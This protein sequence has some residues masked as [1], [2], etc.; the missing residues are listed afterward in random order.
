MGNAS[1]SFAVFTKPWK[2]KTLPELG[3]FVKRLGF[4]AIELPVR[5]GYQV[6]PEDVTAELPKAAKILAN[7]GVR[8]ASIA[9][10]TDERTI[11]AC[12]EAGVPII[13]ICPDLGDEAGYMAAEARLQREF[14]ALLPALARHGVAIGIQNHCGKSV[15]SAMGIRHLIEQYEPK[16]ICAVLDAAHTALEGEEPELALDIVWSHL[17]MVN[18]KNAFRRVSN[19][20]EAEWVR[21]DIYWTTGRQGFAPWHRYAAELHRRNWTGVVCLTAEYSDENA[22]DRLIATDIEYAKSLFR[23]G[24]TS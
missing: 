22:V 3:A 10:P 15:T 18:F 9:G 13:R 19:G 11:A 4:D 8:I 23:Q 6:Q 24:D 2:T 12:G 17:G 20:P 16:Q 14:D 5:P 21:W 1:V 7:E